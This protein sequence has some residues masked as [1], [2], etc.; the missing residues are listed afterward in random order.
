MARA[1]PY[2]ADKY[3]GKPISRAEEVISRGL[4]CLRLAQ[5]EPQQAI[6]YS[7]NLGRDTDC[8]CYLAGTLAAAFRGIRSVPAAWVEAVEPAD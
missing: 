8:C 3:A 6:L 5:G 7:A 4:S 2:Y 1:G